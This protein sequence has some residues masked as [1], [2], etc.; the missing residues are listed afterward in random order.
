M[1]IS[2][3]YVLILILICLLSNQN[4][5]RTS[6]AELIHPTSQ[7]SL[8]E[9]NINND[10]GGIKNFTINLTIP[11]KSTFAEFTVDT[12]TKGEL[13]FTKRFIGNDGKCLYWL[14]VNGDDYPEIIQGTHEQN[15]LFI[16]N[17]NGTLTKIKEFG[18]SYT[19]NI[20]PADYD[21]DGDIDFVIANMSGP[22]CIYENRGNFNFISHMFEDDGTHAYSSSWADVDLD[23]D[24]DL[25][26]GN[27]ICGYVESTNNTLYINDNGEFT[28]LYRFGNYST[29]SI[30]WLYFNNDSYP[31]ICVVNQGSFQFFINNK[32]YSFTEFIIDEEFQYNSSEVGPYGVR[33]MDYDEDND[34]DILVRCGQ[35]LHYFEN[36]NYTYVYNGTII[37]KKIY[38]IIDINQDGELDKVYCDDKL[39]IEIKKN[40]TYKEL[41]LDDKISSGIDLS[42]YDFDKDND[43][44]ILLGQ[45][46]SA[47]ILVNN[48]YIQ[49]TLNLRNELNS[50]LSS[51]PSNLKLLI[52]LSFPNRDLLE[53]TNIT[54]S[55]QLDNDLD[56]ISDELDFDDDNDGYLDEWELL[57]ETDPMD[58]TS[59]PIDTDG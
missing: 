27:G 58:S 9:I 59:Q 1:R 29:I 38:T 18:T 6:T 50:H 14:D 54:Y 4:T 16:N 24:L 12:Y 40:N 36:I 20:D 49:E 25:A 37:D 28:R 57:L 33:I 8:Y 10:D 42:F 35:E 7:S 31:N 46:H 39:I 17:C 15:Y 43:L 2:K 11:A 5:I 53:I 51:N 3:I 21:N 19:Q 48:I 44:D 32:D 41:I 23:G 13:S 30:R 22:S 45:W 26:F 56:S 52:N 55:F 34:T 47:D